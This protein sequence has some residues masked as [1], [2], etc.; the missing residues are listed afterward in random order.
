MSVNSI[1]YKAGI[2][3]TNSLGIQQVK[4]AES[5]EFSQNSEPLSINDK[6][7]VASE[8]A[9]SK[10]QGKFLNFAIDILTYLRNNADGNLDIE[11]ADVEEF[12]MKNYAQ[13]TVNV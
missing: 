4:Q 9:N 1:N 8:F 13:K 12:V 2:Q 3:G 5:K 7:K 6:A 11:A 10:L